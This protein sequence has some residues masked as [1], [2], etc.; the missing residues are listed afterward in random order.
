MHSLSMLGAITPHRP[1]A[2]SAAFAHGQSFIDSQ[3]LVPRLR[4]GP[5]APKIAP[6]LVALSVAAALFI[7]PQSHAQTPATSLQSCFQLIPGQPEVPPQ[8]PLLLNTCTGEAFVLTRAKRA[9][10]RSA[11]FEWLE[12]A[13]PGVAATDP[14][15]GAPEAKAGRDN[16]FTYNG[17]SYC[18]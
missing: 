8:A 12:I 15:K 6:W 13:K 10:A 11:P 9:N 7:A 3:V 4:C 16:C 14:T 18:P 2:P 17:R 5:S 1:V